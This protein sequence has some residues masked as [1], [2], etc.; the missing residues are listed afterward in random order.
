MARLPMS[1]SYASN[2]N[3]YRDVAVVLITTP[4]EDYAGLLV[5]GGQGAVIGIHVYPLVALA[6]ERHPTW[7]AASEPNPPPEVA[8]AIVNDIR[9]LFDRFGIGEPATP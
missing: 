2:S 4:K 8:S 7:L 1:S 9:Q 5:E 3:R 6:F